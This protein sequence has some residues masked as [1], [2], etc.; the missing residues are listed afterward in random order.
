MITAQ[1]MGGTLRTAGAFTAPHTVVLVSLL[2]TMFVLFRELLEELE[3][4]WE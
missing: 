4:S 2:S 1:Q 3:V